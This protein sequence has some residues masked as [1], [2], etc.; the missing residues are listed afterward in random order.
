VCTSTVG[1]TASPSQETGCLSK[2]IL[3]L[4]VINVEKLRELEK[5]AEGKEGRRRGSDFELEQRK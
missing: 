1:G 3:N 5:V 4:E 2:I